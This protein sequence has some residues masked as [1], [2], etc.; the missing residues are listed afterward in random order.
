MVFLFAV[1]VLQRDYPVEH[2]MLRRAVRVGAEVARPQELIALGGLAA[3]RGAGAGEAGFQ[4]A[5][6]QG[7]EA[8][9][10]QIIQ[11]ILAGPVRVRV[12]EPNGWCP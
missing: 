3:L 4:L 11:E 8:G 7:D 5:V 12:A 9:G 1:A 2:Q 10:I 6:L